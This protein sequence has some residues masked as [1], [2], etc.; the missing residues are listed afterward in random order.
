MWNNKQAGRSKKILEAGV[1]KRKGKEREAVSPH[2]K[3]YKAMVIKTVQVA[4]CIFNPQLG[5]CRYSLYA[6][7]Y[8]ILNKSLEHLSILVS[9]E[10]SIIEFIPHGYRGMTVRV[11]ST[12]T[13]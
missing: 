2:I 6:L 12:W 9:S 11:T 13:D 5:V 7:T 4:F 1:R 3:T 10:G 8:A